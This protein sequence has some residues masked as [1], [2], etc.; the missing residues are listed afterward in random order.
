MAEDQDTGDKTELPTERRRE[1]VRERG[2][3]ARSVDLNV[4]ASVLTAAAVLNFFGGDVASSLHDV[5]HRSLSAPAWI[6]LDTPRLM[7]ELLTLSRPVASALLPGLA[8]IM[9][10]AVAV[11]SAQVGFVL[12]TE[13]LSPNFERINP[14]AGARRLLSLQST[15]RM[16]GGLLKL[17]VSTAIVVGF[18]AARIP[19]FLHGVDTDTAS[20]CR[21]LGGWL[22][23]L[24][25]QMSLGLVG[26][27]VLDY[28]FQLW[29]FEQD[30]KMTKQE[31]RDEMRHMEGDP[32]IRQRRRESH[33]KLVSARQ[34]QQARN[35]DVVITN[36]TELAIAIKY[37][38]KKMDAPVVIAKG[39][40]L[41]AAQI[42]RVAAEHGI[43]IIEKKPLAQAL[44]R[45]VKVGQA[46]PADLYE[47]VAEILAYVYRLS[48]QRARRA[49]S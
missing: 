12:T 25:F 46:I 18:I 28:G 40:D 39:K 8:L 47:G 14:L 37:D 38:P 45:L 43:P 26:L 1:E 48:N 5:L 13:P 17:V 4:A 36:P 34:V 6:E 2:N 24:A 23:A 29:R 42:R 31:I 9:V 15:V 33:R 49:R 10:S 32:H 7:N 44:Y 35:A 27:A 41:L 11:N 20:F 22:A 21:Q 3:V 30:I 19:E 16:A